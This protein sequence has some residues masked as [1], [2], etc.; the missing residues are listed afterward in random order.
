MVS[1]FLREEIDYGLRRKG[2]QHQNMSPCHQGGV[3]GKAQAVDVKE[4]QGM[5]QGI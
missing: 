4:R 1:I 3:E 5:T 2:I